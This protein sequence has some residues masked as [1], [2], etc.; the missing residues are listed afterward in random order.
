MYFRLKYRIVESLPSICF[1]YL[2]GQAP[3]SVP[4]LHLYPLFT[5]IRVVTSQSGGYEIRGGD[6]VVGVCGDPV[7]EE[8]SSQTSTQDTI[9]YET[10]N[11]IF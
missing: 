4:L 3:K 2:L 5:Y 11:D 6:D 7:S 1:S 8:S 10:Q 9:G